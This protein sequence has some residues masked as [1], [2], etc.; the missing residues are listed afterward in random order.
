MPE[1]I[2]QIVQH[3]KPGGIESL[4]LTLKQLELAG[5]EIHIVSLEGSKTEGI[6]NWQRLK[7]YSKHIHFLEKKPGI[8]IG[9]IPK[10]IKL[11][12][13]LEIDVIH[14]HHIGPLL[15]AGLA[16]KIAKNTRI[17]HTEH[18]AW[19]LHNLKNRIIQMFLL[20][21]VKPNLVADAKLVASELR[22]KIS[23]ASP[24]VIPNG[25]DTQLFEPGGKE[26][27]RSLFGF[28]QNVK[29][30]GCAARLV[31]VKSIDLL[32]NAFSKLGEDTYL[33]IAGT[34][35]L[36]FELNKL[37]ESLGLCSRV[38]FCGHVEDMVAFYRSLDV[39]CLLSKNEGMPL[40]PLE[41]QAC[42][43]PVIISEVGAT[44]EVL[45]PRTGT[46]VSHQDVQLIAIAIEKTLI[47]KVDISPREFVLK[48]ADVRNMITAY[49]LLYKNRIGGVAI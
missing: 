35:P 28:P 33:V 24:I 9:V 13:Y 17:V 6:S 42:N 38:K 20:K 29:I 11:I 49:Q 2:L 3:L 12:K 43:V 16:A 22:N 8:D 26:L 41:A 14:S 34:G 7:K 44:K 19:H 1:K 37:V 25:I 36:Y 18:D 4:V 40:S 21:I 45:C 47:E 10:L 5:Q 48:S 23:F 39:F 15:Y 31:K 32:I 27:S 30:I 46:L